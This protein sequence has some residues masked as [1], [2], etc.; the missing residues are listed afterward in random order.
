[1]QYKDKLNLKGTLD[2]AIYSTDASVYSQRPSGVVVLG[3]EREII[4]LILSVGRQ[5]SS[6]IPRGAG[7][8]LAGQCVGEGV[9]VDVSKHLNKILDFDPEL[10]QVRVEPGLIRDELNRFLKPHGWFFGP[11]T[12]T[13]NRCTIGGMVGNNSSGSTSIRYGVTRDKVLAIRAV[14]A[15]GSIADFGA[16]QHSFNQYEKALLDLLGPSSIQEGIRSRFPKSSVLRRNT[17]YALDAL[18]DQQPFNPRGEDFNVAKLLCGSEGT[19]AFSSQITLQLDPL[20]PPCVA[21]IAAHFESVHAALLATQVATAHDLYA[22]ELMDKTILDCTKDNRAQRDNRFFIEGD[23]AAIL[24]LELRA[25]TEEELSEKCAALR[26]VLLDHASSFACPVLKGDNIQGLWNLRSA[27][28]G[29]LANLPGPKRAVACIED[30]AV[31]LEDLPS[32][33]AEFEALMERFGQ[34]SVYYAHA[35]A[36]ELHL[37]PILDL[38]DSQDLKDFRQISEEVALLVKKYRGSLSGEHGDGRVRAEFIPLMVG[39]ENYNLFLKVKEIFDSKNILNPGKIVNAKPMDTDLRLSPDQPQLQLETFFD[40]SEDGG[41]MAAVEK[42]NGSGD[43]RQPFSSGGSMCP[44]YQATLDE[45][46]STRGRANALREFISH[47]AEGQKHF[48]HPELKQVLDLCISCKACA[49]ECPSNVDMA[50]MKAEW[51]YQY[52]KI[53]GVSMRSRILGNIELYSAAA[54]RFSFLLNL[55]KRISLLDRSVKKLLSIAPQRSLPSFSSDS[56][57]SW[58]LR[59]KHRAPQSPRSSL[60][61][62]LDEFTDYQDFNTG[63]KAIELLWRLGYEVLWL[64]HSGS[65][66]AMISKGLLASA[67]RQVDRNV[68]LFH[69]HCSPSK[70]LVGIEPSAILGFRDEYPRLASP[71]LRAKAKELSGHTLTIDEFLALEIRKGVITSKDFR[72]NKDKKIVLHGHCHQKA[73]TG[74]RYTKE[75]LKTAGYTTELVPGGCCGMA[76]S[77]GYEKEHYDLSMKI[78]EM[79]LFPTIRESSSN[80]VILVATGTSC[81]HQ[82]ADGLSREAK[83]WVHIV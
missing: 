17:G 31:A 65:A 16:K 4:D 3:A 75:I 70:P 83:H 28:L 80:E 43:C 5:G 38:R 62:F 8:S 61:L 56:V 78:A 45:K 13:S 81:R 76:G 41:F 77:F 82:I 37:R 25:D 9:I 7:T 15:D 21:L 42:C 47:T 51:Q 11:N 44:S 59:N 12:S 10:G 69:P 19:L 55:S 57:H 40:Y 73:I 48:D 74:M 14:M 68:S 33:I 18:I 67:R 29:L 72:A 6:V 34:K 24:A 71:A 50:S 39:Q 26:G 54:S 52:Q 22:C 64:P 60:Y 36:G 35:G 46:D 79:H 30:T 2:S 27:G 1:M 49:R 63:V 53:H 66:R 58:F 20:P 23:P 32:Y